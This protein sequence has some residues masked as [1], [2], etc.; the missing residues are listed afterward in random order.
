MLGAS[1][2]RARSQPVAPIKALGLEV[3]L[4]H[5]AGA[6]QNHAVAEVIM[7]AEQAEADLLQDAVWA[8]GL[9]PA[10]QC[11]ELYGW[12]DKAPPLV[13]SSPASSAA[14]ADQVDKEQALAACLATPFTYD[15][16]SL[17]K[18]AQESVRRLADERHR[19]TN[20]RFLQEV[21]SEEEDRRDSDGRSGRETTS[22]AGH[23]AVRR[24][25]RRRRHEDLLPDLLG[26]T[27]PAPSLLSTSPD[28]KCKLDNV[29]C[30][31]EDESN[32]LTISG[33]ELARKTQSHLTV[34][35]QEPDACVF[36]MD[37]PPGFVDKG[38]YARD[39]YDEGDYPSM[40]EAALSTSAYHPALT[41]CVSFDGWAGDACPGTAIPESGM[42]TDVPMNSE[43]LQTVPDSPSEGKVTTASD[44][45]D[46]ATGAPAAGNAQSSSS[47]QV[48]NR[49]KLASKKT[50]DVVARAGSS[51]KNGDQQEA[52]TGTGSNRHVRSN[53]VPFRKTNSSEP[54]SLP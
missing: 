34:D 33:D 8:K 5:M 37:L 24:D 36:S 31:L 51:M 20:A 27:A 7:E 14:Q 28:T 53:A 2:A 45:A 46:K 25:R 16:S 41:S 21:G 4:A 9:L 10:S 35:L 39:A 40:D 17:A 15:D 12:I 22:F 13:D 49:S 19:S 32:T 54:V 1:A 50:I 48:T 29:L 38:N 26:S 47:S 11:F 52:V 30:A 3:A 18:S 43:L 23:Q 6:P 44:A 42:A